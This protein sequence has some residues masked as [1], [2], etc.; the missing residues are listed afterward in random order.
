MRFGTAA[1]AG[2]L[3]RYQLNYNTMIVP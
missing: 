2:P 1:N 3:V